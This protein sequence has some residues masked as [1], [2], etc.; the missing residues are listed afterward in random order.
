ML[1]MKNIRERRRS[2]RRIGT[3]R[4][5]EWNHKYRKWRL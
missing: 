5:L 2:H 1:L 4:N 3:L